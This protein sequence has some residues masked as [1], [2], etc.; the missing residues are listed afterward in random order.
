M[1]KRRHSNRRRRRGSFGFLY[2]V[3][4][5]LVIC[6]AIIAALTLFFRVDT[7]VVTGEQRY[8]EETVIKAT[9]VER[10]DNL[11]LLNKYAVANEIIGALPY[12]E[13]IRINRKLPDTLIVE[14]KECGESLAIVQDG[15]AW[16]ISPKGKIVEQ[17][18][19][20]ASEEY[21][22]IT[23]CQLLAP[24]V[25]TPL[26]LATEYALQQQSL[27][28]L[29][30]ALETANMLTEAESISLQDL[31]ILTMDYGGR[32]RVEMPY[33]ADYPRKLRALQAV[34]DNLETNQTGTVQLTWDNGEVHFIEN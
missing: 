15:F 29:L 4:S 5:M 1:A 17:T 10:G 28:E 18:E 33:G 30:N 16:L 2:K 34:I 20:A 23:D 24:S 9:G 22:T 3:L 31:S 13:E 11:F 32:F 8:T 7:I 25:G 12:I 27:L 19:T 26:A 14:V 6:G 21:I